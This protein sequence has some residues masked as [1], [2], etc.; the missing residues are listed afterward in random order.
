MLVRRFLLLLLLACF[1]VDTLYAMSIREAIPAAVSAIK[2]KN[3]DGRMLSLGDIRGKKGTLVLFSCNHCPY[4]KAWEERIAS[5]GNSYQSKGVGVVAINS[6]DPAVFAE[7]SFAEMQQRAKERGFRFPYVV[8]ATS[9]VARAFGATRTPEVFLFDAAGKLF[10]HGAID[11][12]SRH[13]DEVK[14]HYLRDALEALLANKTIDKP[15][16]KFIGCRIKERQGSK[17]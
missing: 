2:M 16:R 3:V 4:V 13:A 10:Y 11:D 6:N 1:M 14:E 15:E 17:P 9:D 12:N 7:D 5:I 8:D